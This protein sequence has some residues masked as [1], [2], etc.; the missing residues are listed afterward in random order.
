MLLARLQE[1]LAKQQLSA[2]FQPIVGMQNG[3]IIGYEGLIRGP[4]DS[5]LH[6]PMDLFKVA[7]ANN[8][9]VKVEHMCR[10]VVLES[11]ARLALPGKLFLNVSPEA[12]LQPDATHGE[13]LDSIQRLGISPERLIIELTESQPTSDYELLRKAVTHY[14]NMGFQI[15]I[16]DL[17]EGFS[18]LRLWS[19][20]RP[21]YVKIDM[22]FIQGINRDPVKLQFVRSIQEIA[23]TSGTVVIAE[24]IETQ[25]EMLIVRDLGIACGQGYHIARPHSAPAITLA[26][27]VVQSLARDDRHYFAAD[28]ITSSGVSKKN[29]ATAFRLVRVVP[30]ATPEMPNHA[31][32]AMFH[33]TPDLH[34][35]PVVG[36]GIVLGLIT[37]ANLLQQCA[38]PY[39]KEL[40]AEKACT[41]FMDCQPIIVDQ[42]TTLYDLSQTIAVAER[43]HLF[44]GFVIA[45][46]G[47]YLGMGNAQDL[48]REMARIEHVAE[49][50][51]DALMLRSPHVA[52]GSLNHH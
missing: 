23:Q 40:H 50:F 24:G 28:V 29:I 48:I 15:A 19:E 26:S 13:T 4:S 22:H 7:K 2:L 46:Q 45:D 9:T 52:S 51:P 38:S 27:E 3:E 36:N 44:N 1:I 16:D 32:H 43:H 12:L 5:P 18:S 20:L 30:I 11:F 6:A 14:R 37:R 21:E 34:V 10:R 17:G 35:I 25:I 39:L 31:V 49:G 33:D 41:L 47:Q 8:L 42:S